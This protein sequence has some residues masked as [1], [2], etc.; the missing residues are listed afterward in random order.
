MPITLP[1]ASTANTESNATITANVANA[2]TLFIASTTVLINNA[3]A[4]GF[5]QVEPFVIPW[6]NIANI[7][8]YF[9]GLGYTV[10]FP[11]VE[12][13]PYNPCFVAGFPEVLPPGYIPWNCCCGCGCQA[14]R[15][16]ISWPP[17]PAVPPF[18]YCP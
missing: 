10:L 7:T 16:K 18:P 9:Q 14:P 8:T 12:P 4:N 15:I 17:F 3:T 13:G 1:D 6:L 11:I 5:F 2:Q